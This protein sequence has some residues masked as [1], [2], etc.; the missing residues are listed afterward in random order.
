MALPAAAAVQVSGAMA[1]ADK[2][3][4]RAERALENVRQTSSRSSRYSADAVGLKEALNGGAGPD[5]TT[6]AGV[7]EAMDEFARHV[8]TRGESCAL[9]LAWHETHPVVGGPALPPNARLKKK[10][11][12][13]KSQPRFV[14]HSSR[15][16]QR[17]PT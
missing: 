13:L 11:S 8:S 10:S 2:L 6:R 17:T 12:S 15:A 5:W 3:L 4:L 16:A 7:A 9:R 14:L 1:A